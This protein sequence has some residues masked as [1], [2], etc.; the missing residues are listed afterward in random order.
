MS[1]DLADRYLELSQKREAM[2]QAVEDLLKYLGKDL[3]FFQSPLGEALERLY[4]APLKGMGRLEDALVLY[5]GLMDIMESPELGYLSDAAALVI[6]LVHKDL[7]E[8]T[9]DKALTS[10][11]IHE[12]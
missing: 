12:L 3:D 4:E 8:E 5:E 2:K 10:M 1:Y 7:D 9:A 6:Y 11:M